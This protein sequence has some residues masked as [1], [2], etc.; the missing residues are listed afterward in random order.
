LNTKNTISYTIE[1]GG[2]SAATFNAPI[3]SKLQAE[4]TALAGLATNKSESHMRIFHRIKKIK[5]L[6]LQ[7]YSDILT[8]P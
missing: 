2:Q 8:V 1:I 7:G 3:N 5:A 4:R 6:D